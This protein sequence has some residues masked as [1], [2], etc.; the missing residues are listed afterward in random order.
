MKRKSCDIL[1]H[2]H[3]GLLFSFTMSV[4][5]LQSFFFFFSFGWSKFWWLTVFWVWNARG[6]RSRHPQPLKWWNEMKIVDDNYR[7]WSH[8][9]MYMCKSLA[10]P[11]VIMYGWT[12]NNPAKEKRWWG[13]RKW[14]EKERKERKDRTEMWVSV[15]DIDF[16]SLC[17]TKLVVS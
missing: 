9:S 7:K 11:N 3:H 8:I 13:G 1:Y 17:I 14:Q 10:D 16:F 6:W 12:I 5:M 4:G 15:R 2:H